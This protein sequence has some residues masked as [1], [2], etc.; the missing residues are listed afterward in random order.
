MLK[1]IDLTY[2]LIVNGIIL[3]NQR[4]KE[5]DKFIKKVLKENIP[6]VGF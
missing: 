4:E 1:K 3:I 2:K 6:I 5:D